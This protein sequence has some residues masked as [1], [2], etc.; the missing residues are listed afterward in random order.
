MSL[1]N[2][3]ANIDNLLD[4]IDDIKERISILENYP[5]VSGEGIVYNVKD[6]GAIGDGTADDTAAIQLTISQINPGEFSTV[7]LPIGTYNISSSLIIDSQIRF[8]GS[9]NTT[10]MVATANITM[11]K[12]EQ[13]CE[14]SELKMYGNDR[15]SSSSIGIQ[16]GGNAA[17]SINVQAVIR[18]VR[19]ATGFYYAIYS[20]F[21]IDR[22][23]I[24][25]IQMFN[26]VTKGG[27]YIAWDEVTGA[28]SANVTIRRCTLSP[29]V[30]AISGEASY[31]V[32][33]RG[34]DNFLMEQNTI[35]HWD[36]CVFISGTSVAGVF[37]FVIDGLHTEERRTGIYNGTRWSA[38]L[39]V[40]ADDLILPTKDNATGFVYKAQGS[41][42]TGGS[43]PTWPIAYGGTVVDND[44]T[45]EAY[46]RSVAIQIGA[47]VREVAINGV[48]SEA[49]IYGISDNSNARIDA[50]TLH[51]TDHDYAFIRRGNGPSYWSMR[52]SYMVGNFKPFV[53]APAGTDSVLEFLNVKWLNDN[54]G[55]IPTAHGYSAYKLPINFPT[56]PRGTTS[57]STFD[58]D[59]RAFRYIIANSISNDVTI[60][61]PAINASLE[62]IV[63]TVLKYHT[64]NNVIVDA[65][66]IG[67]T[68]IRTS[69]G[70][71]NTR[72]ITTR[73]GHL[74]LTPLQTPG[75]FH[76]MILSEAL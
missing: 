64:S 34:A 37:N 61:L 54:L 23:V 67:G 18:N 8:M 65:N 50:R 12:M 39:G 14:V 31:G 7:F 43:E 73:A 28:K 71:A 1:A 17:V 63:F 11:I 75:G 44:I 69:A 62:G 33:V 3:D 10:L 47:F 21:P 72:T 16:I 26:P 5:N 66:T 19:F 42:T 48:Y 35:N 46:T 53:S 27:I 49:Q 32:F 20:D 57:A 68:V 70:T 36:N 58:P 76:W 25:N 22:A 45:W 41:G 24:E 6:Y 2:R 55:Y 60:R 15:T 38:S 56:I 40:S 13:D 51:M 9:G 74:T 4:Q 52:N 30:G 59:I 29:G